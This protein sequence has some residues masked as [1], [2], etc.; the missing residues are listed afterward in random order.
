MVKTGKLRVSVIGCGYIS[1]RHFLSWNALPQT[2]VVAICDIDKNRA[3]QRAKQFGIPQIFTSIEELLEKVRCEIIDITTRP[4]SHREL[5][6]FAANPKSA[7]ISV[8]QSTDRNDLL[9]GADIVIT[10]IGVGGRKAW[11][12]DVFIPRKYEIYHPVIKDIDLSPSI[13]ENKARR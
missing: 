11:E 3:E 5:V 10:T 7:D 13:K 4:D 12:T 2:E 8:K 6:T 1:E 9:P